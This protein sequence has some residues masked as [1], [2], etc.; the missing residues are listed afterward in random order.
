MDYQ[1]FTIRLLHKPHPVP[2][3]YLH[4]LHF[5]ILPESEEALEMGSR[6][7]L[8]FNHRKLVLGRVRLGQVIALQMVCFA[9]RQ[10]FKHVCAKPN[11]TSSL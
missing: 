6:I 4:W 8:S 3:L 1:H 5:C 11:G 7:D 9:F 2:E 10:R